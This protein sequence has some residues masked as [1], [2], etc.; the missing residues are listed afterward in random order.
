MKKVI[1]S[2][3]VAG[4]LLAT[5]C[6]K[7]K[8]AANDVK[9]TTETVADDTKKAAETVVKETKEAVT[10]ATTGAVESALE[11]I[12]IPEFKNPKVGEFL[13]TY[14]EYAKEYIAANGDVAK[15]TKLSAKSAELA[16]QGQALS[17]AL[18][19]ESA[20]KY[21]KVMQAIMAKMAPAAK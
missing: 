1:L 8:E 19:A 15:I 7:A 17:G 2:V 6:K 14:S 10:E 5:S 11:G 18:D 4:S 21:A 13:K 12:T 3:L 16:Q 20:P 9:T